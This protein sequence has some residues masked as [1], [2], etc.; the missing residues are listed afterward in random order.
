MLGIALRA[1]K[2][3]GSLFAAKTA[4]APEFRS[5]RFVFGHKIF[6]LKFKVTF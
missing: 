3:V 5:M 1:L 6:L 4:F 2:K